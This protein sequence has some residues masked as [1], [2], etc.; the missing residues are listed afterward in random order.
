MS[1]DRTFPPGSSP[2]SRSVP[3]DRLRQGPDGYTVEAT[4][5][6][7]AALAADFGLPAIHALSG[8]FRAD[9]P[10]TRLVVTGTVEARITQTCSVTLEPFETEVSEPVEVAFTDTDRLAGTDAEDEDVP[11]PIVGGRIDLGALTAE[12]LALGLDPYPRKPGVAFE[13]HEE[14]AEKPLA[15]LHRLK[16]REG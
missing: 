1:A 16:G 13:P 15:A 12:F 5:E 11:D 9:G 7:C 10:T 2:L 8:H 4:P 14:A 3:V 6:E